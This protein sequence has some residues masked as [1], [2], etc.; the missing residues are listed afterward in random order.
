LF[1]LYL[2]IIRCYI[3]I[4]SIVQ[5][6]NSR[7]HRLIVSINNSNPCVVIGTII[8][9][10]TFEVLFLKASIFHLLVELESIFEIGWA[11]WF[12]SLG[13]HILWALTLLMHWAS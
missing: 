4:I 3:A 7:N 2:R 13:V 9:V 10:V 11:L 8:D 6:V 12:I 5:I 1:V